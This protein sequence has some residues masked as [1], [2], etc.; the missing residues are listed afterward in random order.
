V[1]A[2]DGRSEVRPI[3]PLACCFDHRV[4]NGMDA[5]NFLNALKD[6]LET[7]PVEQ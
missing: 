5:A 4:W 3:L 1:V 7:R 6:K 2:V